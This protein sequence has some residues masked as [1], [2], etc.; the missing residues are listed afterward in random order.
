MK[1]LLIICLLFVS[2]LSAHGFEWGEQY[3]GDRKR[4]QEMR[5][6]VHDCNELMRTAFDEGSWTEAIFEGK[7]LIRLFPDTPFSSEAEY[8]VGMSYFKRGDNEF[9][10][11]HFSKY[12]SKENSP[13]YFEDVIR[14][15]FKIANAFE[16]GAKRHV[17]GWEKMPSWMS[18]YEEA[19][20]IY[21][22]VIATL[23]RDDMAAQSLYKKGRI[24]LLMESYERSLEAF[25]TLIRRF[26]KHPSVPDAY[27]GILDVYLTKSEK[28]FPDPDL[29][30]LA[31]INLRKFRTHSPRD[32]RLEEG[33][34]LLLD[35]E[36]LH[37]ANFY[38]IARY[39]ERK[40][41]KKAAALYY[42]NI[43]RKFPRTEV[44]RDSIERFEN[45]GFTFEEL[46]ADEVLPTSDL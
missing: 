41:K 16:K 28:K 46:S 43:M 42:S 9:A 38:D 13:K 21:D 30:E 14:M 35:L 44:A 7:R 24:L 37:A 15:K 3:N 23:P 2:S 40:D 11:Y 34:K 20:K 36:E 5:L 26:P 22:E 18:A 25:E 31:S 1:N 33:E 39:F 29:L 17:F 12:L 45:L 10:N 8:Y 27:L 4:V 6:S 19:V 32:P